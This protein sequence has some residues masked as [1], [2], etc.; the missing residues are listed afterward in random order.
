MRRL[1]L[2]A[3]HNLSVLLGGAAILFTSSSLVAQDTI[4]DVMSSVVSFQYYDSLTD[5]ANSPIASL[6]VSYQFYDSLIDMGVN[7]LIVS[8]V[9]S[10]QYF[11]WPGDLVLSLQDSPDVS[12]F[13]AWGLGNLTILMQ[14]VTQHAA[15]G[16]SVTFSVG[17]DGQEPLDYQWQFNGQDIAGETNSSL[18]LNSVTA[19]SSGGYAVIVSN[20]YGSV[21]SATAFLSVLADGANGNQPAQI[22][23]Q[24]L[25]S[26]PSAAKNL[27][28][29]THGW[30]PGLTQSVQWVSDMANAIQQRVSSDWYVVPYL[31]LDQ[32]S[33]LNPDDALS[34]AKI[35]GAQLGKEIGDA[36]QCVHL[37]G[38]S[39][40]AG[41]I[42]AAADAIREASPGT[43]IQ[44]T[45]LDP[46]TGQFLEG[47]GEYGHNASWSDDY[48][49]VDFLTD[50]AGVLLLQAP[51]STSGQLQWA[52]NVDVG[53]TLQAAVQVPV[54]YSGI[55]GSTPPV[56]DT[57]PS[58]SHG[59]PIDFYVSTV[60]GT[61]P[62]CAAGYG[63]PLSLEAG[64]SANWPL[65]G[66]GN[67]PFPLCG[68][69]S[70]PQN[71]APIRSDPVLN[72]S[73]L[74]S[75][76]SRSGATIVGAGA[77]A[78]TA[79]G[80]SWLAVSLGITNPANFVQFDASF[81]DANS[82]QGLLT[83]YWSTNEIGMV[84]ERAAAPGFQTYR[85]ALPGV[86]RVR[87]PHIEFQARHLRGHVEH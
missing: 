7:S 55:A 37:I 38:H 35:I 18:L 54:Y 80:P 79:D 13:Y 10:Y 39:A 43:T 24:P 9:A 81:T 82:A 36:F 76:T 46:F 48:F 22:V 72:L 73:F 74:P 27:V 2:T 63:F 26:K 4:T 8:P 47:R 71:Q 34:N 60:D 87:A 86:C 53:G 29:I 51:D 6:P 44:T 52:Y 5:Q 64:G 75:S 25:P 77:A 50:E 66:P 30:D 16:T 65:Y 12:Y 15:A 41:L 59:T 68:T 45:F 40:G 78:L 11:D 31:W 20:P 67:A 33:A 23:A 19:A 85:F 58:P 3:L 17:A 61:A 21:A 83:V 32:A 56:I 62:S 49:V 28:L 84:D 57:S 42:Q 69:S 70:L 14:P 1:L